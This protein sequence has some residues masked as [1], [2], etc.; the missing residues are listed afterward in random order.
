MIDIVVENM[1]PYQKSNEI[2]GTEFS[3]ENGFENVLVYYKKQ[4]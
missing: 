1:H 3:L 2:I 4:E